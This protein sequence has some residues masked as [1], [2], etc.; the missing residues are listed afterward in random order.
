MILLMMTNFE[1]RVEF[2]DNLQRMNDGPIMVFIRKDIQNYFDLRGKYSI[3]LKSSGI[4]EADFP[5]NTK[6][7]DS[8]LPD[9]AVDLP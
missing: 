1:I 6:S 9:R 4:S 2:T 3:A 5:E 7:K 8:L